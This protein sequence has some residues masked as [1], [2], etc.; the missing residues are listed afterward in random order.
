MKP[1]LRDRII[2]ELNG[3]LGLCPIPS[4]RENILLERHSQEELFGIIQKL[5]DGIIELRKK[6]GDAEWIE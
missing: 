1:P 2:T 5:V 3:L 4:K 6:L